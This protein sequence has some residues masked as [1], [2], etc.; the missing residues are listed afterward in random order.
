[1]K[2]HAKLLIGFLIAAVV[3]GVASWYL[4]QHNVAV[5][6]PAG[7]IGHKERNL[8]VFTVLLSVLIVVPVFLLLGYIAWHYHEDNTKAKYSP[9]HGGSRVAETVW[10]L[11]P[12]LLLVIISVVTWRSS[13]ALDPYKHLASSK[14][15]LHIQ[16]VALDWKW[17]FIYPDQKVASVNEVAIPVDTPVDF[18]ITSDTVMTSFWIPQLGSQMYAMPGMATHLNLLADKTGNYEG[19]AANISGKGFAGMKFTTKVVSDDDYAAWLRNAKKAPRKLTASTYAALAKPSENNKPMR[20][21]SVDSS[22]Y[23]TIMMNYMMPMGDTTSDQPNESEGMHA[24]TDTMHG[25]DM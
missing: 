9:D 19:V 11:V 6:E 23:D 17:L 4:G 10:W 15:T 21:S 25:M 16:V 12:S 1:M 8:I 2:K 22:L 14:R 13:Y 7:P 24:H 20:Y 18:E 3:V 5:L